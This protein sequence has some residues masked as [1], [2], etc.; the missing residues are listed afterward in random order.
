MNELQTHWV[1]EKSWTYR[2]KFSAGPKVDGAR[3]VL[4]FEGLDTFAT[5]RLN[6]AE[7]LKSEN[8]FISHHVDV[9]TELTYDSPNTIEIDFDSA[10]LRA[11]EIGKE[12]PEHRFIGHQTE[13][14]RIGV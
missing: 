10:L 4:V 12:H 14:E 7:I 1:G 2:C 13:P 6:D 5:V 3:S 9:T 8:M 11:R